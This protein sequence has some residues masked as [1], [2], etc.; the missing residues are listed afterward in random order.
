MRTPADKRRRPSGCSSA[1]GLL[2][3][4]GV[5]SRSEE[6]TVGRTGPAH[7][8][9]A[10]AGGWRARRLPGSVAAVES[11]PL[12]D[13]IG[14]GYAA[15][16]R[17][18]PRI[19]TAI[20]AALGDARR[21]LDVGAGAGSY[22]PGDRAVVAL[23][24]SAMML[25]QRPRGAA[26]AVRGVAEALPF[27]DGGFDAAMAVLTLHHWQDLGAGLAELR[28]VAPRQV[29]FLF[30]PLEV[31]RFWAVEYFPEAVD[32]PS[33]RRAPGVA[34][35]RAALEVREVRVVPVPIDCTDGFGAAYWGRPEAYLDPAV[36]ASQSWLAQLDERHRTAGA[37]RLAD[38]LASGRWD[39]RFGHLRQLDE[40]DVG[41]R[42][43]L[44][45]TG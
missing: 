17:A 6:A 43:V 44:A 36:Q 19:A 20:E 26:P 13:A 14:T 37:R 25:A 22:E 39:E 1:T 29:V 31:R 8:V 7:P 40:L 34:Q 10:G 42:L 12:Y 21:V 2:T 38:D 18:D 41:Y 23:E 28:R 24:P 27:P 33:E 32:V 30:E 11:R 9:P 3:L 16:R 15:H 4:G 45:G 35:L 5:P